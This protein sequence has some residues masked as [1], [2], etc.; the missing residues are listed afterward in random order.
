MICHIEEVGQPFFHLCL[1]TAP[2]VTLLSWLLLFPIVSV[3][4][5][6]RLRVPVSIV[7]WP[8]VRTCRL[9][10]FCVL[11]LCVCFIRLLRLPPYLTPVTGWSRDGAC[12]FPS[13]TCFMATKTLIR[14]HLQ[15]PP[16]Q[17]CIGTGRTAFGSPNSIYLSNPK[18]GIKQIEQFS[19][20]ILR[21]LRFLRSRLESQ[22]WNSF[23]PF[24]L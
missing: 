23:N 3:V 10:L 9:S 14:P 20:I 4:V 2:L 13:L 19:D 24:P 21:I 5:L 18:M 6:W 16:L 11:L 22:S 7:F 17:S 12:L 15:V 1:C 8:R